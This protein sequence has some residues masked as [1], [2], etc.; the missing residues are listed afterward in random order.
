[1]NRVRVPYRG[2]GHMSVRASK[3]LTWAGAAFGFASLVGGSVAHADD[4]TSLGLDPGRARATA[5]KSGATF[6][7]AWNANPASSAIVASPLVADG[8]VVLAGAR[9][10]VTALRAVDGT[11][12]WTVKAPGDVGASPAI[13]AG[14][15]F[16][17]T[18]NGQLQALHL[19]TGAEAWSQA[20]GGQNYSSP[21]VVDDSLGKGLVVAAGFPQQKIVRL[22]LSTGTSQWETARGV[23]GDLVNSSAAL[24]G[25]RLTFGVNGGRYQTFDALTGAASWNATA[26]GAVGLSTPLVAGTAAYFLPGGKTATLYA[27]DAATGAPLA[28]WPVQALDPAAPAAATVVGARVAVSSP[29]LAGGL[30]VFTA[31]FEYDLAAKPNGA[32]GTHPL[33]ELV[34]AVDPAKIAVAWQLEIGRREAAT[35]NEVPELNLAPTPVVFATD[36][37]P[38]LALASSIV[39]TVRV[40][41]LAGA[42]QWSTSLSAPTRSSP[43]LANGLLIVATDVGVVHAFASNVNHAPVIA[44]DGYSP[45]EGELVDGP[46]QTL[47]WAAASD[48][49]GQ[50]VK[51]QVRVVAADGDLCETWLKQLDAEPSATS[52][53]L[54]RGELKAGL[55][56]RYAVRA[57]DAFGAWS[58]WSTE[59]SFTLAIPAKI[60][61]GGQSFDTLAE[62]IASLPASGG[63]VNVGRGLVRLHATLVLPAGVS[64]VGAGP[65]DTVLD[66]TGQVAGV[67]MKSGGGTGASSLKSVTVTGAEVGVQVVDVQN[68]V[69]RNLVLRDNKKV[70][71]QVEEGAAA[72]AINLTIARNPTGASVS[73]K[74]AIR[75][76]IV[77]GNDKGLERVGTGQVTSRYNDVVDNVTAGYAGFAAGTGDLA[78]TV[79]F[80]STADFHLAGLQPTTDMGDP[81]DAFALE[82]LP[83]GARVNMGAFGN[84][85]TAELSRSSEGWTTAAT[86]RAVSAGPS[87][88]G[89]STPSGTPP[90]G[91]GSG[92]SV[93]PMPS[94]TGGA[95]AWFVLALSAGGALL[96]GRRRRE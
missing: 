84:T 48:A 10:D 88:V 75:S 47:S 34:V 76:S 78:A 25:G 77:T 26:N 94:E 80:R 19:S 33:H 51:Y 14:R 49:E 1:M 32:P 59:R 54:A 57:R 31:R 23:V 16:L 60:D 65:H 17:P 52:V 27:A 7:P 21:I 43:V 91:G 11:Q 73:G 20:F 40:L 61:V 9:G 89:D 41:D 68:A 87:P 92:C 45:A 62:A 55:T 8:L 95:F 85:T 42:E 37:N 72:D 90:G 3:S 53:V 18:L 28:G 15:I 13:D 38:L 93:A 70:G 69:L 96:M 58:D 5:E 24:S 67:Q 6:S 36:G 71:V 4:W 63:V 29:V 83:N 66:A 74:L 46:T 56:Y 86:T 81:A 39:P 79:T 50:T 12:A 22:G 35:L 2:V 44:T 64:I 82:P 30:V